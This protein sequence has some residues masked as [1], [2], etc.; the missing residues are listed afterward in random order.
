MKEETKG[1]ILIGIALII[2]LGVIYFWWTTTPFAKEDNKEPQIKTLT[3]SKDNFLI[4]NNNYFISLNPETC[5]KG[6]LG[7]CSWTGTSPCDKMAY[8]ATFRLLNFPSEIDT[9]TL[10]EVNSN[11]QIRAYSNGE[12]IGYKNQDGTLQKLMFTYTNSQSTPDIMLPLKYTQDNNL[13]FCFKI[14]GTEFYHTS[15]PPGVY[16]KIY[17]NEIC[18]DNIN[19]PAKC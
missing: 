3:L 17:S 9:S 8:I 1:Y 14:N 7:D 15:N 19:I 16:P 6:K 4:I 5:Q 10:T 13:V 11:L 2:V 18:L 12:E